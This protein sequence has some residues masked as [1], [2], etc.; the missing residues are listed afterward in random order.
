MTVR[1][2]RSSGPIL[3]KA[4]GGCASEEP[5]WYQHVSSGNEDPLAQ[6]DD[7]FALVQEV[8]L[9]DPAQQEYFCLSGALGHATWLANDVTDGGSLE[10]GL[11]HLY[12]CPPRV[13][14]RGFLGW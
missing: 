14:V 1:G 12:D 10:T 11:I 8:T 3:L 13:G 6:R 4:K 7:T 2:R 5:T 9:R